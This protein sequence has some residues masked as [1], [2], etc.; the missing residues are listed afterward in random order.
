M[1]NNS[2][3][4]AIEYVIDDVINIKNYRIVLHVRENILTKFEFRR[5]TAGKDI[6]KNEGGE[7]INDVINTKN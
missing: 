2:M 3:I 7:V 1:H 5:P 4:F 6:I